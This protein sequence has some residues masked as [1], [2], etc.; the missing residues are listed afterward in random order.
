MKRML[1]AVLITTLAL[2]TTA[3]AKTAMTSE[4][5]H[6]DAASCK[7]KYGGGPL[8]QNVKIFNVFYNTGNTYRDMLTSYYTAVT[9]SAYFDWLIEYNS[10]SYKIGRGSFL[11]Y[12][13]DTNSATTKTTLD[14]TDIGP[15]LDK[16]IAANK[17]PAPDDNT[18]YQIYFPSN[19]TITLQ[20]SQS[21]SVFCAYH[22]G[23]DH[24][25]SQRGRYSVI[26][27]V[28]KSPC[29]GGC[30]NSA[31]QFNNLTSVSSHEMIEAVTDPDDNSAWVDTSSQSCG[32][33]GD[34]CNAQQGTIGSYTVQKEW[35][36]S[37]TSCIVTN[38]NIMVNTFTV[39]PTP[40]M[41][42][43]PAGGMATVMVALAKTAGT[44]ETVALT[45]KAPT[46]VTAAF[47]PA[48]VASDAGKSTLTVTAS[49][50]A[51][52][53]S[54]GDITITAT[55]S[56]TAPTATVAVTITAP[57]DMAMAPDMAEP[58]SSG[59]SGGT[60]GGGSGG[61]NG[62]GTGG[63]GGSG[64]SGNG[65]RGGSDSG[66]SMSGGSIAGSW[67]FAGFLLLALAFRRRRA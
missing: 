12:Y 53:G 7:L 67:A 1:G 49:P 4:P 44:S 20:G 50:T 63:N 65:N 2:S 21:C 37:L 36:N 5:A 25:S 14:D 61:G 45:A 39:T 28:T 16:L 11:G 40:T 35:S 22:N 9:Q 31:T 27:D 33:I 42:S 29:A 19:V 15:Y 23:W 46:G 24:T 26:P 43:V 34:I 6:P 54:A 32:E 38:P 58:V 60:G 48:S 47:S 51:T 13:E 10:G 57:P 18:L 8:L 52:V 64:G 17:I 3:N 62:T 66:C 30:G 55:G 41:V 59:G 56:S